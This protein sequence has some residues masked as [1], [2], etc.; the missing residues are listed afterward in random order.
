MA[1]CPSCQA[2]CPEGAAICP[3]CGVK[4]PPSPVGRVLGDRYRI[5][6]RI[7]EGGMGTVWLCEHVA[8]GKRMAVKIL[9][10][11]FSRDEELARRFEQ[12]ARAA[13]QIGQENIIDVVD[14]GRTPEGS[15]YL[16]MEALEGESLAR[17]LRRA[18]PLPVGRAIGILLQ[19]CRALGAAHAR[20]IVHRDL[21]PE[22]VIVVRREDG[23]DFAKVVDFGISK[24]GGSAEQGRITRAGSIIGTPEYMAPEQASAAAVDHRCDV[25]ALGVLAYEMLTGSLPFQG[26]TAVATLLKHQG[27]RPA[28][29]RQRRPDLPAELEA[30]ILRALAKD[31]A[32]RQQSMAELAAEIGRFAGGPEAEAA[33]AGLP[34]ASALGAAPGSTARFLAPPRP[35]SR[36]DTVA[37]SAA[38]VDPG[39]RARRKRILLGASVAA[40]A[41]IAGLTWLA[42]GRA[43]APPAPPPIPA[44]PAPPAAAELPPPAAPPASG[45][46]APLAPALHRVTL[47]SIPSGATVYQGSDRIGVTPL[48]VEIPFGRGNVYRFDR[49]GYRSLSRRVEAADGTVEVRLAKVERAG[50]LGAAAKG[51]ENPRGKV[52]DLKP[53]PFR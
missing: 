38:E 39:R 23:S 32:D 19:I 50:K 47:R 37:L 11:E 8:L 2:R 21:K 51:G 46:A 53:D 40:A 35:S 24:S 22:N 9:R 29:P 43:P 49:A 25:Y 28:P 18:G 13:S 33:P 48:D 10:P 12:E 36:G 5:L 27:E 14:F 44:A 15:L 7:G 45:P 31:P 34:P 20:G 1:P 3:V 41:A 16:V 42:P 52:G 4:L 26:E 6:E 30:A 17:L